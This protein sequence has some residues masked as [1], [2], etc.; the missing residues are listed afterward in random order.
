M[1]TVTVEDGTGVANANSYISEADFTTYAEQHGWDLTPYETDAI[2]AAIIRA[3]QAIDTGYR[4]RFPGVQTYEA[5]QAMEWPRKAG[6]VHPVQGTFVAYAPATL[7]LGTGWP[8]AIDAVPA[9]LKQAQNEGAWRELQQPGALQPDLE[10]GGGIKAM[11]AGSVSITYGD[12][13]PGGTVFSAVE[14]LMDAL[15][16]A[17][18]KLTARANRV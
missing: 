17:S 15:L 13:A 5:A 1:V 4:A 14:S 7:L 3:A 11:S 6:Y 12:G 9:L 2:A 8:V 10:R 18:S 16:G